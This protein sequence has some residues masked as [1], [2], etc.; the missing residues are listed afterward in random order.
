MW[1]WIT[2]N[3]AA[4]TMLVNVVMAG[5]WLAYLQIFLVSFQRSNRVVVHVGMADE[6]DG[7]ARCIVSNMGSST[8]YIIAV[9]VE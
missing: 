1:S 5:I 4:L 8:V 7:D 6:R 9:L 2:Q 3:A